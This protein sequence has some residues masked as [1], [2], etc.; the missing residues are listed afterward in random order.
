M[1]ARAAWRLESLGFSDVLRYT[2]GKADWLANQLPWAGE[3]KQAR[4]AG[5]L[6]RVDVPTCRL[7]DRIGDVQERVRTENCNICVVVNNEQV[8]LGLLENVEQFDPSQTTHAVMVSAPKTYRPDTAL[9]P[10]REYMHKHDQTHVLV[11]TSDG[12]LL[13][14]LRRADLD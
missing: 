10:V 13:G 1:S 12:V 11:T 4:H 2:P 9:D 7:Q 6:A 3:Q 14:A 8:V 5:D